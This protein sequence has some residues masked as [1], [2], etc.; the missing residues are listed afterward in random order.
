MGVDPLNY[1]RLQEYEDFVA[2]A[3]AEQNQLQ[4]C[5]STATCL[6]CIH[7]NEGDSTAEHSWTSTNSQT[8]HGGS[9][10]SKAKGSKAKLTLIFTCILG[11]ATARLSAVECSLLDAPWGLVGWCR[12]DVTIQRK[13]YRHLPAACC[14]TTLHASWAGSVP[15]RSLSLPANSLRLLITPSDLHKSAASIMPTVCHCW[16]ILLL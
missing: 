5:G 14:T 11:K 16:C 6:S 3:D 15:A 2:H 8:V 7:F 10:H 13:Q 1:C 12:G 4:H 9:T